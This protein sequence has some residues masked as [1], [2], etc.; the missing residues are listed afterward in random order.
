[1][2]GWGYWGYLRAYYSINRETEWAHGRLGRIASVRD[3]H[4]LARRVARCAR[5][6]RRAK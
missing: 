4:R 5:Q 3:A 2:N 1:M 6:E